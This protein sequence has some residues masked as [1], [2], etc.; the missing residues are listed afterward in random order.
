MA[1]KDHRQQRIP[2]DHAT[3]P[4]KLNRRRSNTLSPEMGRRLPPQF[5]TRHGEVCG[6]WA[7]DG[8]REAEGGTGTD[9]RRELPMF[10]RD[11][12]KPH[13]A[14]A[15][16]RT[17]YLQPPCP[18]SCASL[19]GTPAD[20]PLPRPLLKPLLGFTSGW[21][22]RKTRKQ[23]LPIFAQPDVPWPLSRGDHQGR[24]DGYVINSAGSAVV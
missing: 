7:K 17:A 20:A 16:P 4:R 18:R 2:S 6:A 12:G 13:E 21:V 23:K 3:H 1:C 14:A 10:R 19:S 15:T 9:D 8:R 11:L 5:R 22:L 24:K